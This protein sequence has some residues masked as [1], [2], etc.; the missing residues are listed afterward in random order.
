MVDQHALP[1]H[2]DIGHIDVLRKRGGRVRVIMASR[3]LPFL[4]FCSG[5]SL[6]NIMIADSIIISL[7]HKIKLVPFVKLGSMSP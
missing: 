3:G 1:L 5:F 4:L 6:P 2:Y 7:F